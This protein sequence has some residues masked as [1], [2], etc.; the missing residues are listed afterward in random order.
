LISRELTS[1]VSPNHLTSAFQQ[2]KR[3][4]RVENGLIRL[5]DGS[6]DCPP[7]KVGGATGKIFIQSALLILPLL[8]AR[9][10]FAV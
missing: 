4:E 9:L 3:I 10:V 8:I 6:T 5:M 7:Q 2:K 1:P